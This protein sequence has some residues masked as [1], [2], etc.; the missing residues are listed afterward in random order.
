[1]PNKRSGPSGHS[2]QLEGPEKEAQA[3]A[4]EALALAA[5]LSLAQP[6]YAPLGRKLGISGERVRTAHQGTKV[7]PETLERWRKAL[8]S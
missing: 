4:V 1:M 3:Q 8:T 6:W 7:R 5:G 2:P